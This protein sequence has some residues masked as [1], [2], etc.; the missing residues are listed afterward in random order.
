MTVTLYLSESP[1]LN[2]NPI[3]MGT[4]TVPVDLQAS[5]HKTITV[6][7]TAVPGDLLAAGD[8]YYFVAKITSPT[9]V[10]SDDQNGMDA[11]NVNATPRTFEF[12]GT[13]AD[14]PRV[15][16][17]GTYFQF[18]RDTLNGDKVEE[19]QNVDVTNMKKFITAFEGEILYPYRDQKGIPTIGVGINLKTLASDVKA[20]LAQSVRTYYLKYY[21]KRLSKN[22]DAVISM[23]KQQAMPEG[24]KRH[25][26]I[27][28]TEPDSQRLLVE[29]LS[30]VV[31]GVRGK[32]GL[33]TYDG[34]SAAEQ[35]A[36]VDL[37]YNVGSVFPGVASDLE[38][39]DF[40]LAGFDLVDA[41]RST[42]G[43]NLGRRTEAEYQNL[44][45]G[46]LADLGQFVS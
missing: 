22:D 8:K 9:I 33:S 37:A 34:L 3:N 19:V 38:A 7:V 23:L 32:L 21:G 35:V 31:A 16:R 10:E 18:V 11:N 14:N 42:Q 40:V 44:L 41:I 28:L 12:L 45:A 25:A 24:S 17:D 6:G 5:A 39:L 15:F 27:A 20:D 36:V 30:H 26:P 4:A 13:P 2:A 1:D 29:V 46:H 43:G